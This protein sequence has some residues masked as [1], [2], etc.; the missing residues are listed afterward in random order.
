MPQ[1][2]KLLITPNAYFHVFNRGVKNRDIFHEAG[3]YQRF[4][5]LLKRYVHPVAHILS[6]ALMRNHF[7][8]T[9]L[10]RPSQDIPA[11]LLKT[12]ATLGRTFGHLQ[13]AYAKYYNLRYNKVS[14]LFERSYERKQVDSLAYLKQLI[15][16]HHLNPEKHEEATNFKHHWWT[17]FQEYS[18]P[19]VDSVINHQL[20]FAKFG[21]KEAFFAAHEEP[22][23]LAME[24]W[25]P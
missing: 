20:G 4:L 3:D 2:P 11:A 21:G 14:G 23:P 10:M 13:N 25:E 19:L 7:H 16:Y 22:V 1:T 8:L 24:D 9:V 17:S 6:F 15:L 5:K 18:N 12:P